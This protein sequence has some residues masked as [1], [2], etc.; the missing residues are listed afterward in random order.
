MAVYMDLG[1]LARSTTWLCANAIYEQEAKS[2][3]ELGELGKATAGPD[4]RKGGHPCW[5]NIM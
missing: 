3:W 2:I 5:H 1:D 4:R